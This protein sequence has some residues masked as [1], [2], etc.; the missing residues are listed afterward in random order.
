MHPT[1]HATEAP[2]TYAQ[3]L[4]RQILR[5]QSARSKADAFRHQRR[6]GLSEAIVDTLFATPAREART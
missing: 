2:E 6:A 1:P 4:A 5:A 3:A